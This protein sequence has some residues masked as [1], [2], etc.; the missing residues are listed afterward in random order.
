MLIKKLESEHMGENRKYRSRFWK[1]SRWVLTLCVALVV[2]FPLGL[3]A[4]TT[5][6]ASDQ[7]SGYGTGV[8]SPLQFAGE[9]APENLVDLSFGASAFYDDNVLGSNIDR[10]SD[11]ALSLN[12]R[13][14]IARQTEHLSLNFGYTPFFQLYR[15]FSQYDQL[16][17]TANLNLAARLSPRFVLGLY[18]GFGY[19]YGG[20]PTLTEQP[21]LTGSAPPTALNLLILPYTVR[22]LSNTTGVNLTFEKS[23]RTSVTLSG[24]Y[25]LDRFGNQGGVGGALYNSK[26]AS[27]GI[28]LNYRTTEH[29]R[30][31]FHLLH[32]DDT[33]RGGGV[34]RYQQRTQIES[35][36]FS[37]KSQLSPTLT[38]TLNGGP[39]YVHTL[40]HSS[41]QP[42]LAGGFYGAG[43]GS[44]TEEVRNTA[45]TFSV[46]RNVSDGGG[47]YTSVISTS[48]NLGVRRR[49]VGR[50]EADLHG[51]AERGTTQFSQVGNEK[52]DVVIGG[53][54]FRR[55][56]L[57]GSILHISYATM[58]ELNKGTFQVFQGFDRN[59]VSIGVD[60]RVKA[61]SLGQ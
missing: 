24:G 42:G 32:Q 49:L 13:L 57:N 39:Q 48:A 8:Q 51:G 31:G 37:V 26:G 36:L 46:Q 23:R 28:A 21:I 34:F 18:D 7:G 5:S 55:P 53:L 54:D 2:L 3:A 27:G 47:L 43:G 9:N 40:G 22:T 58:H 19:L 44:V 12:S 14:D 15:Q 61:F 38:V 56:I 33:Y 50:W 1:N 16:N 6:S 20:Y 59:Q 52:T 30:F 4:Q 17:Q 25:N 41:G 29:T 10:V 45:L 35:G 11:E 60:F